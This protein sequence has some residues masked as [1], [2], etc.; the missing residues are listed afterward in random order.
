MRANSMSATQ[1]AD[2]FGIPLAMDGFK[3][4]I[5]SEEVFEEWLLRV[6]T[7][8]QAEI[9]LRGALEKSQGRRPRKQA[10]F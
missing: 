7:A 3:R 10:Q 1:K 5:A 9:T 6:L 4:V 8:R 2:L